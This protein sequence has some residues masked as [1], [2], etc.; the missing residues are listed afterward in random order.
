MLPK[1][2]LLDLDDTII[3]FDAGSE[4]AWINVCNDFCDKRNL[5]NPQSMN[6]GSGT[7][8]IRKDIGLAEII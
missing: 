8:V 2:I 5:S 3:S 7:G 4:A 1:A 6:T